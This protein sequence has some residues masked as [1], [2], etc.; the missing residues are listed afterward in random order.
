MGK[1][2][3]MLLAQRGAHVAIIAR[4]PAKLDSALEEIR[5]A[6][7]SAEQKV[8]LYSA[9]LT[10]GGEAAAALAAVQAEL[11][12]PDIVW[13]CAGGTQP[14]YFKDYS[15]AALEREIGINYFTV[16]HTAHAALRLMTSA[17]ATEDGRKRHIVFTSSVLAFYPIAG[18]NSYSPAKAAIRALADGLRQECLLYDIEVHACF[19]ATIY[20]PGFEEEQKTKPELTKILEGSDEG[21]TPQQVAEECLK[22]LERGE[23]L[24]TTTLMGSVIRG[25]AWGGSPKGFFDTLFAMVLVLVWS[26]VGRVVD[27]DVVKYKKKLEKE[28]KADGK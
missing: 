6:R 28:G 4:N 5:A 17:G 24:V 21:Q 27:G 3:A 20:S 11:G 1:S 26:V 13:T 15:S 7:R 19:P 9:D 22:G 14:G 12:T 8:F 16:M 2:V 23:A 18:Y 25:S 10:R